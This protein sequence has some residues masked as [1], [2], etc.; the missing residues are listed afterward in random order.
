MIYSGYCSFSGDFG[1]FKS[2]TLVNDYHSINLFQ[3]P[4]KLKSIDAL[5]PTFKNSGI[6]T[7][8]YIIFYLFCF[9]ILTYKNILNIYK[10]IKRS[11][12]I[13]CI[14]D[15]ILKTNKYRLMYTRNADD[16]IKLNI[17]YF[18]IT[19]PPKR[20]LLHNILQSINYKIDL[21]DVCHKHNGKFRKH[22]E[23]PRLNIL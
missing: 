13:T 10:N 18:F 21:L 7:I 14:I 1:Y 20:F 12:I 5:N 6:Y 22:L 23:L 11:K 16:S 8:T 3:N 19:T 17:L 4:E 15:G 2:F 9:F